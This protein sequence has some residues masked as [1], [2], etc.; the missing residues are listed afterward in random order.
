MHIGV[1]ESLFILEDG[2]HFPLD[3]GNSIERYRFYFGG[4]TT[5]PAASTIQ[6]EATIGDFTLGVRF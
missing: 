1:V 2:T 5:Y 4:D 6:R 3:H